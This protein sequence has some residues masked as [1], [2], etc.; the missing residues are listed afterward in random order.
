[1]LNVEKLKA[2]S[3]RAGTRER[4]PLSP[5]FFNILS[6]VLTTTIRKEKELQGTQIGKRE[7]K[8]SLFIDDILYLEN[9]KYST[10]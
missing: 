6:E 7:A 5:L 1:M 9:P 8:V 3:Q 4:Y 2:F 10:K